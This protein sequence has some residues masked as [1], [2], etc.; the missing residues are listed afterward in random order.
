MW[1]CLS[2]KKSLRPVLWLICFSQTLDP[3]SQSFFYF[4]HLSFYG[5]ATTDQAPYQVLL[6]VILHCKIV[7]TKYLLSAVIYMCV[8]L[9]YFIISPQRE[10]KKKPRESFDLV[11]HLEDYVSKS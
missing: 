9:K 4:V 2:S 6:H 7:H 8:L 11:G 3:W 10:K 5:V 1:E